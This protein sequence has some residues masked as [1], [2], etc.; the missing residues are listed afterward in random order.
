[1]VDFDPSSR[2]RSGAVPDAAAPAAGVLDA[3]ALARLRELDPTG[4]GGLLE[5]VLRAFE[6]SVARLVPQL[7]EGRAGGDLQ[8][9]AHVAHTLKSSSASIGALELSRL[10]ADCEHRVR[11][12]R[13]EGLDAVL[14]QIRQQIDLTVAAL[15]RLLAVR[16]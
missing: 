13:T 11:E 6:A 8:A 5:R 12:A 2:E 10:C 7:E 16:T 15:R 4:Q 9:V 14:D 1:M 3:Q